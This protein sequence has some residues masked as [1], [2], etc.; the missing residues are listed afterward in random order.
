MPR[1]LVRATRELSTTDWTGGWARSASSL[2]WIQ[3]QQA[4]VGPL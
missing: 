1:V 4:R 2:E 3:D